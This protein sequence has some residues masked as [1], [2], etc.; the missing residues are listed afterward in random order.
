[1]TIERSVF[2]GM[3]NEQISKMDTIIDLLSHGHKVNP[4]CRMED[5]VH[6]KT[7]Y[8]ILAKGDYKPKRIA[9]MLAS[10]PNSLG[11]Q[12]ILANNEMAEFMGI[13]VMYRDY[14]DVLPEK[15]EPKILPVTVYAEKIGKANVWHDLI[16]DAIGG[17]NVKEVKRHLGVY[18]NC[19]GWAASHGGTVIPCTK[20]TVLSI[21][22]QGRFRCAT[23]SDALTKARKKGSASV[24]TSVVDDV[25]KGILG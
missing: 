25:L 20:G 15:V 3:V 22:D 6:A 21:K 23:C 5:V 16:L 4:P 17:K 8:H 18:I 24:S 11:G 13:I 1:M 12:N 7:M 2:V 9:S 19:V 10:L 14:S